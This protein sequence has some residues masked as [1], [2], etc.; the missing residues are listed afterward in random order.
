MFIIYFIYYVIFTQEYHI[1]A[2]EKALLAYFQ[3]GRYDRFSCYFIKQ[4]VF[5]CVAWCCCLNKGP[6]SQEYL[7]ARGRANVILRPLSR[8]LDR[9]DRMIQTESRDSKAVIQAL[10]LFTAAMCTS[11]CQ[12]RTYN[13]RANARLSALLYTCISYIASLSIA[14]AFS[15]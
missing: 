13:L 10:C 2:H 3:G 12:L 14:M 8:R 4:C 5:V 9:Y 1:C 7:P 6:F 15:R 11:Q